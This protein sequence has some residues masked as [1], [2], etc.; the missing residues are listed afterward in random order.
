[1]SIKAKLKEVWNDNKEEIISIGLIAL[2]TAAATCVGVAVGKYIGFYNGATAMTNFAKTGINGLGGKE[3][4][5]LMVKNT[6]TYGK[7]NQ[8]EKVIL[9]M[10]AQ[11]FNNTVDLVK[12]RSQATIPVNPTPAPQTVT[13]QPTVG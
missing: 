2:G 12:A 3:Y 7:C 1:M 5:D 13:I 10:C 11:D 8:N 9:D 4:S 6:I